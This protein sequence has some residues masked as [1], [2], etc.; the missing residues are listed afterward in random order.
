MKPL[1]GKPIIWHIY[2]RAEKCKLVDKIIVATSTDKTDDLLARYCEL[3]ELNVY[4]GSLNN[5]LSRFIEILTKY[6]YPYFVRIT[7][8]CPLIHPPFIDAQI[9]VLAEYNADIIWSKKEST[10]LE[11]QGVR[12]TQS[13]FYIADKSSHP[14]DQEHVG[15]IYLS[16]HPDEFRI[17]EI[18][19]P[20]IFIN[21]D[22][23]LTIDE[24][25]DYLLFI[26]IFD[27]LFQEYKEPELLDVI[28][29]L[30]DNEQILS[31]NKGVAHKEL[32]IKLKKIR[33]KWINIKKTG[34]I[35]LNL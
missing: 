11:G 21:N 14:D 15:I 1:A 23:R 18:E 10:L 26:E 6:D 31:I 17:V 29:W 12:S 7:G 30:K 3:N 34:K 16:K 5:V 28:Y 32:N 13:L 2:K 27:A 20:D 19:L 24:E 22:F 35:T 8:D 25:K 33:E 4:R 9:E